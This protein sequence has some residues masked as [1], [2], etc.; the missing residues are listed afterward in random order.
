M[1]FEFIDNPNSGILKAGLTSEQVKNIFQSKV[2]EFIKT[3]LCKV[4]K[5]AFYDGNTTKQ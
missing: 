4:K 1:I 3:P 2:F 5:D